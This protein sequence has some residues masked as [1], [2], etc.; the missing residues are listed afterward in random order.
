MSSSTAVDSDAGLSL[1]NDV[2]LRCYSSL[3]PWTQ[4]HSDSSNA[5]LTSPLVSCA[6]LLRSETHSSPSA[7][8]AVFLSDLASTCSDSTQSSSSLTFV[9]AAN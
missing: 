6:R 8:S 5:R 9:A 1:Q 7:V 2:Y 3:Y 4:D